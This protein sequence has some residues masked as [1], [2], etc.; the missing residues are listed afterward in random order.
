M[1]SGCDRIVIFLRS[2]NWVKKRRMALVACLAG[3]IVLCG[4]RLILHNDDDDDAGN[5]AVQAE[6][7]DIGEALWHGLHPSSLNTDFHGAPT[8]TPI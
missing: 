3:V 4:A 2:A 6:Y 1:R 7:L 8:V 5:D